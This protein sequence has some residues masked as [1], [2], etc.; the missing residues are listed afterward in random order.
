MAQVK[1]IFSDWFIWIFLFLFWGVSSALSPFF[2]TLSTFST[3]MLTAVPIALVALG[4]TYVILTGEFDLSVGAVAS[5]ATAI[6]SVT[7]QL[8]W[9]AS[10]LLVLL[11]ALLIG[12]L[13]GLA[14]I[15]L[16]VG[17]FIITLAVMF[18]INGVALIIRPSPGGFIAREFEDLMLYDVG[19]F[20]VTA[21]LILAVAGIVGELLLQR[22][23]LGREIYA[24]GGNAEAAKAMGINVNKVK[25]IVF[26][27]SG[28]CA[29]LAGLF[30]A[31]RIRSGNAIV[32]APYLFDSFTAVFM[33]G[34][35]V[36]GGIGNYR[37]SLAAAL[38]IASISR[39]LQFLEV[40]IWY[41]FVIKGL[42]LLSVAGAQLI[43]VK[44]RGLILA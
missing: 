39:I 34:T 18:I 22:R 10:V 1:K 25:T 21:F 23:V 30:V 44:R 40:S 12:F 2:R 31:A 41:Q 36:T 32:G 27:I 3:I 26:M 42:L 28:V 16:R 24:T 38:L 15:K 29:A 43:I 19:G 20:P 5:L 35:L 8:N 4:Q 6:A 14:L 7:M 13:N 17:S 9:P 33:G 37:N 11:V